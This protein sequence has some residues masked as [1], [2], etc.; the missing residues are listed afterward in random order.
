MHRSPYHSNHAYEF[1]IGKSIER[2]N[3][4]RE[5]GIPPRVRNMRL[6]AMRFY[7]T[8][9]IMIARISGIGFGPPL[10]KGSSISEH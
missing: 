5:P 6:N 9:A 2:R 4:S 10:R 8:T 3:S 1:H 7:S